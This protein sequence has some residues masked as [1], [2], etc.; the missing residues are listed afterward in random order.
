ML[1]S[2]VSPIWIII[3]VWTDNC[4]DCTLAA[5]TSWSI[6][7]QTMSSL[8]GETNSIMVIIIGV[9]FAEI[10]PKFIPPYCNLFTILTTCTQDK[11]GWREVQFPREGQDVSPCLDSSWGKPSSSSSST[12]PSPSSTSSSPPTL[13]AQAMSKSP[14]DINVRAA[15]MWSYAVLLWELAT[16]QESNFDLEVLLFGAQ[17]DDLDAGWRK[18]CGGTGGPRRKV[19]TWTKIL[20][21]NIRYFVPN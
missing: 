18:L 5:N 16:R 12:P 15:D 11:H 17:D 7:F 8:L 3:S 10:Q 1:A 21:P 2:M 20:S 9:I 6:V 14:S 13:S 19:W 4:P